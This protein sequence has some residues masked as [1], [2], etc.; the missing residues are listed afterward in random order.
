MIFDIDIL[1]DIDY[2]DVY[3]LKSLCNNKSILSRRLLIY[4]KMEKTIILFDNKYMQC[5]L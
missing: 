3:D 5:V 2:N 1:F 4:V